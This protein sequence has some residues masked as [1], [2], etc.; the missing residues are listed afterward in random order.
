MARADTETAKP[1]LPPAPMDK[2]VTRAVELLHNTQDKSTG[3]WSAGRAS[4]QNIAVSSLAVMAFLSAGHVPGEGKY[5]KTIERGVRWVLEQQ[6]P[7]GVLA[8]EGE[9]D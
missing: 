5:G 4:R 7:N 9:G 1:L 6:R 8:G 3:S 2:A